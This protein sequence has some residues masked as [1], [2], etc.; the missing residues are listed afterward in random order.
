MRFRNLSPTKCQ[1]RD[2]DEFHEKA[3]SLRCVVATQGVPMAAN[4]GCADKG[5]STA[6]SQC[7]Y[8]AGLIG[9]LDCL[10]SSIL[11]SSLCCDKVFA[12]TPRSVAHRES[13]GAPCR[14]PRSSTARIRCSKAARTPSRRI[15]P[16]VGRSHITGTPAWSNR[17]TRRV[18]TSKITCV[19][20]SWICTRSH[21]PAAEL[22]VQTTAFITSI[23][24]LNLPLRSQAWAP[25]N[26]RSLAAAR[27]LTSAL[28]ASG[29][30]Q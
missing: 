28:G 18:A 27:A 16:S 10:L 11:A 26:L 25:S 23:A 21:P 13:P 22:R 24:L 2:A 19:P 30:P 14:F 12:S 15:F 20:S 8:L 5:L 4:L 7:F 1:R 3:E 29:S 9:R 6:K 17:T